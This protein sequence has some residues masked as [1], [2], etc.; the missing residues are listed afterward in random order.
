MIAIGALSPWRKPHFKT[1]TS[2]WSLAQRAFFLRR[3][4]PNDT[5]ALRAGNAQRLQRF[6]ARFQR[7]IGE[8][9]LATGRV[10]DFLSLAWRRSSIRYSSAMTACFG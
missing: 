4:N 2:D 5:K 8:P 6:E 3:E 1:R 7:V 10:L 9:A